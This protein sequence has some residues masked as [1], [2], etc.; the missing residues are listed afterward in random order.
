MVVIL[1][2][3]FIF[4]AVIGSFLNVVVER[5]PKNLSIV[6]PPSHCPHCKHK[7]AWYDLIPVVSYILLKGTCRYCHVKISRYY[8]FFEILTGISFIGI[9]LFAIQGGILYTIYLL[10]ITSIFIVIF[11]TD[12]KYGIIPVYAVMIGCMAVLAYLLYTISFQTLFIHFL[13]ALGAFA[14]FFLLFAVTK[15]RGM[16]FGD[17]MLVVLLGFFLGFPGIA[18]GLYLAFVGGA[19]F[20]LILIVARNKR[21]RHDTIPFGPFLI[22]GTFAALFYGQT[23]ISIV[24]QYMPFNGFL[25]L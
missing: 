2:L 14:F 16:G 21:L 9:Y 24:T 8:P 12:Y 25:G 3:L 11:F 10:F 7:L 18:I 17:V 6:Y 19:L 4:G 22:L 20:S 13:S 5:A 23:I 15:G 1:L